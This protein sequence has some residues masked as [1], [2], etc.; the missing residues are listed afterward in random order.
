MKI[1]IG[2]RRMAIL[3]RTRETLNKVL[4]VP[5]LHVKVIAV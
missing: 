3:S 5:R 2:L 4:S 1:N